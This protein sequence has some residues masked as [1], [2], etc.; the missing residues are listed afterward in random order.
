V[1]LTGLKAAY[2][3]VHAILDVQIIISTYSEVWYTITNFTEAITA[4]INYTA[5]EMCVALHLYHIALYHKKLECL[6]WVHHALMVG[7]SLPLLTLIP[8]GSLLGFGLFFTTGLPVVIQHTLDFLSFNKITSRGRAIHIFVFQH[9]WIRAP[10]CCACAALGLVSANVQGFTG[11]V[12]YAICISSA[13]SY[14][15]GQYLMRR[16]VEANVKRAERE[17]RKQE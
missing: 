12:L 6:E 8:S 14:W 15:N 10:G 1:T 2:Y 3:A 16:V 9:V 17:S 11:N 7:V 5:V 4:P 13:L